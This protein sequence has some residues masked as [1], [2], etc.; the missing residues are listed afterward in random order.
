MKQWPSIIVDVLYLF[1]GALCF[2]GLAA[3]YLIH[4]DVSWY[5]VDLYLFPALIGVIIGGLFRIASIRQAHE[6]QLQASTDF[7]S[8][9]VLTLCASCK[10]IRIDHEH[11]LDPNS[12][13]SIEW[14]LSYLTDLPSSHG[15]CPTCADRLLDEI[16]HDRRTERTET[17]IRPG[18]G[19]TH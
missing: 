4:L 11:P 3:L 16:E 2:A 10:K 8:R 15:I 13:R 19:S 17:S 7:S 18:E 1:C 12:W 6:V 5:S 14:Y 9:D